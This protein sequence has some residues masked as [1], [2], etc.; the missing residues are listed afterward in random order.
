[1]I[2]SRNRTADLLKGVAVILMVQVH[3]VSFQF[4]KNFTNQL[5][6]MG[7]N[8]T[9]YY[10]TQ[11]LLIGNISAGIYKTQNSFQLLLVWFLLI[12]ILT[13]LLTLTWI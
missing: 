2:T 3:I 11:R 7:R 10:V 13:T 12:V 6:W 9:V 8:V 4:P 5:E 1:M